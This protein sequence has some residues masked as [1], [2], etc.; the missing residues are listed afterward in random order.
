[1]AEQKRQ[2]IQL[3]LGSVGKSDIS[4][5]DIESAARKDAINVK[6]FRMKN[7]PNLLGAI[8]IIRFAKQHQ[9]DI[10]HCHG[11]KANILMGMLPAC[12]RVIP[13]LVT[14][15]GWTSIKKFSKM[16]IYGW[17]EALFAKRA[18]MATVVSTAM[19]NHPRISAVGLKTI[20]IHN[21]IPQVGLPQKVPPPPNNL[22]HCFSHKGFK[23]L[24]I[25]RL[26]PEK[27]FDL[28]VNAISKLI[29]NGHDISLVI[30]GEGAER[31]RLENLAQIRG[32]AD[33]VFFTGYLDQASRYLRHFDLFVISSITEGLPITLLET[34]QAGVP[35]VATRVGGIPEVLDN[36]KYGLLVDP[37]NENELADA[38]T[39]L[40]NS[41]E[42][43]NEMRK[44][45]REA[46][47]HD[48]SSEN[49]ERD[50]R[51][52]YEKLVQIRSK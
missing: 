13:Y 21:G 42:K 38:I 3:I 35:I 19:K 4:E 1:M 11:Y 30:I 12:F 47:K 52:V 5:K 24:A 36:G 39:K 2:G 31:K 27:G 14:I 7:G 15:H 23:I 18:D 40:Y 6:E 46:V 16:W 49:M 43:R 32:V 44:A 17:S 48:F 45:A 50:Y 34:M 22:F 51:E 41:P 10:I 28:L 9:V 29:N 8:S 26:S 33:K 37:G 25:G 20:V